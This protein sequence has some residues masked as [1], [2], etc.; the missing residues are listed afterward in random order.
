[1][2]R[3]L[4][5]MVTVI[6]GAS[7][8]IGKALAIDLSGRGARL[9]LAARRFEL[10]QELNRSLGGKHLCIK[11]D[12]SSADDCEMLIN[13][14]L[15]HYGRIDTLV[16]NAG[17][18]LARSF[19][20][21]SREDVRHIF[22]A[23]LIGTVECCR[24]AVAAMKHQSPLQGYRGQ[25]MMVS[26][27][28]ARR[29]L[30]FFSTY[31][32]TKAA[33]LSLAEGLRIELRPFGI[34]VTS[35]HPMLADTDFFSTV[36]EVSGMSP[37]ALANGSRQTAATVAAKMVRAIQ[38]PRGEVWPKAFSR[39]ALTISASIP[40]IVD[41]VMARICNRIVQENEAA[42]RPVDVAPRQKPHREQRTE[43]NAS[44]S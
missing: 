41:I 14:T 28:C 5:N 24:H 43:A 1:M 37:N 20:K 32:A 7:S 38:R 3:D 22:D 8:G 9:V 34:A 27:A 4:Q 19:D 44:V 12:V 25:L 39:L 40:S 23:N 13:E 36:V 35:V 11:A 30:P 17:Y 15:N 42:D 31:A 6:T 29:G 2:T 16:C 21:M 10:L 33:Q 26:S 18:G